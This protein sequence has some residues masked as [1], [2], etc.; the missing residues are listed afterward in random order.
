MAFYPWP[1][2]HFQFGKLKASEEPPSPPPPAADTTTSEV[3]A[4]ATGRSKIGTVVYTSLGRWLQQVYTQ[5]PFTD[6]I[7]VYGP[8]AYCEVSVD[9][10]M[11]VPVTVGEEAYSL[12]VDRLRTQFWD[13]CEYQFFFTPPGRKQGQINVS[14]EFGYSAD[15]GDDRGSFEVTRIDGQG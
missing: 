7:G 14:G 1:S 3:G 13:S 2:I 8:D 9:P 15:E 4:T 6:D 11:V 12:R 5:D 10:P